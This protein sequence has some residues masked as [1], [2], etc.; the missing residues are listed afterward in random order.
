MASAKGLTPPNSATNCL[1]LEIMVTTH[2]P[3]LGTMQALHTLGLPPA[4]VW[5]HTDAMKEPY[6][7]VGR[8]LVRLAEALELNGAEIARR[9]DNQIR[10]SRWTEY[11]KGSRLITVENALELHRL[12]GVTLD[13]IYRGDESGLPQS[14]TKKLYN[15]A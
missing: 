9:T 15:A 12:C 13:Y 2:I 1:T 8:R 4:T 6:E 14:V 10:P 11:T 5:R 3:Y 7:D